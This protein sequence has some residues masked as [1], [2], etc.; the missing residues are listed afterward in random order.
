MAQQRVNMAY[1]LGLMEADG[2]ILLMFGTGNSRTTLK[3]VIRITQKTN[4]NVLALIKTWFDEQEINSEYEDWDPKTSRGRARNLAITRVGSVRKF[5]SLVKKEKLQF[6]NQK[7][8]DFM[9]LD[10]VMNSPT[11]L[12][13]SDKVN[14][15]KSLHK[16]DMNQPDLDQPGAKTREQLELRYNILLGTS[17]QDSLGI[18]AKIDASYAA[19]TDKIKNQ[20]TKGTLD[21]PPEWMAG[22]LDGDGCYYVSIQVREPSAS[23]SKP[24]IEFQG[25]FT[26]TM[27]KNALL[28]VEA[29]RAAVKSEAK[30]KEEEGHCQLWIRN[31]T[32]VKALLQLQQAYLPVGNHRLEQYQLVSQLYAYKEQGKMRDLDTVLSVLRASYSISE[33]CKGRER[34]HTLAKMEEIARQIYG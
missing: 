12:S 30:I 10:V 17:R 2:S 26:L 22:L 27:E 15:K 34:T 3:P 24:Y 13:I 19:H 11:T 31:Q 28:T 23:Y 6:I 29:V 4:S 9:I 33:K 18:L 7:Q 1:I 16:A 20:I 5:I 21:I 25:D 14:L 32:E 8:R